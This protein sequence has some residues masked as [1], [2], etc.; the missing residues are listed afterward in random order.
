MKHTPNNASRIVWPIFLFPLLSPLPVRL[1]A[2]HGCRS[3]GRCCGMLLWCGN[4][5]KKKWC[6]FLCL[7]AQIQPCG[8]CAATHLKVFRIIRFTAFLEL[9]GVRKNDKKGKTSGIFLCVSKKQID[10]KLSTYDNG[11]RLG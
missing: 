1:L 4:P 5:N 11:R 3:L 10:S 8:L 6:H 2:I 9:V 7:R